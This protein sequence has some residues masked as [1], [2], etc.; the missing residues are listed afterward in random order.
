MGVRN[1]VLFSSLPKLSL[2]LDK[3]HSLTSLQTPWIHRDI[4]LR[5]LPVIDPL[6]LFALLSYGCD[7]QAGMTNTNIMQ[8]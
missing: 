8:I 4:S 1:D 7:G 2:N 5:I 6:A 3:I